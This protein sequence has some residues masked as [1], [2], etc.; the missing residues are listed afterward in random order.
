VTEAVV[1]GRW[2]RLTVLVTVACWLVQAPLSGGIAQPRKRLPRPLAE[3]T[4]DERF[5]RVDI[6]E[7]EYLRLKPLLKCSA[8]GSP[9]GQ[10]VR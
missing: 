4:L 1:G 8:T 5:A 6:D 9:G 2:R 7:V 10:P 3:T